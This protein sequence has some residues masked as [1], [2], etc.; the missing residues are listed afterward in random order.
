ID[1]GRFLEFGVGS[2]DAGVMLD[3]GDE[4][5]AVG[6]EVAFER[7]LVSW[8]EVAAIAAATD[9]QARQRLLLHANAGQVAVLLKDIFNVLLLLATARAHAV[10]MMREVAT[11]LIG[12]EHLD[13]VDDTLMVEAMIHLPDLDLL[14]DNLAR[15]EVAVRLLEVIIPERV[16]AGA[17]L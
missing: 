11:P 15:L 12:F 7:E 9:A 1:L 13:P 10:K 14:E 8:E 5:G 16:F 3:A 4:I 6:V 2:L 17:E